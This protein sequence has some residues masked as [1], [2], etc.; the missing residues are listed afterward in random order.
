MNKV[1]ESIL[2]SAAVSTRVIPNG[3]DLET[4]RPGDRDAAR[5]QLGLPADARVLLFI[6]NRWI[7]GSQAKDYPT[8][9]EAI[10][11][12]GSQLRDRSLIFLALGEANPTEIIGN[13]E[14]RF[15]PYQDD[16]SVVALHYQAADVY[17][18]AAHADTFPT[19]VLEALACG[20]P[21]VAT[22]ICGIPEQIKGWS[23]A[24]IEVGGHNCHG[25]HT[26]TGVLV[27]HAD[28]NQ[29]ANAVI[30]LLEND[31][32]R[33]AL[34]TNARA[35]ACARFDLKEQIDAYLEWYEQI[36]TRRCEA[37]T[38]TASVANSRD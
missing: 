29:M 14:I 18:H 30:R 10:R 3:V 23:G 21:V 25:K 11:L 1:R 20:V 2:F 8:M 32:V 17:M 33:T 16:P 22:A 36:L 27:N 31:G 9:R 35:D 12:V 5:R 13:A 37:A 19:T 34:S 6:A 26:A 4:F 28:A 24:G 15:L 7:R 38:D